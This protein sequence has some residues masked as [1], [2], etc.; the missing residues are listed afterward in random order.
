[1]RWRKG[2]PK[3]VV[4]WHSHGVGRTNGSQVAQV[5][6]NVENMAQKEGLGAA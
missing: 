1:M 5:V 4:D 2:I 3:V 6:E